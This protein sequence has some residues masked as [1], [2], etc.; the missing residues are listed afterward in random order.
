[1]VPAVHAHA[2]CLSDYTTRSSSA[3]FLLSHPAYFSFLNYISS[4]SILCFVERKTLFYFCIG[5]KHFFYPVRVPIL[6]T[7]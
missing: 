6:D 4:F 5:E 7:Y 3:L 2:Y 1:M